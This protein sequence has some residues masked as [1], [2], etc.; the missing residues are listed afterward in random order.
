MKKAKR[1]Q[2]IRNLPQVTQSGREGIQTGVAP[3]HG[4]GSPPP[5]PAE[6]HLQN[7]SPPRAPG[8]PCQSRVTVARM[9][10]DTEPARP[11]NTNREGPS[12]QEAQIQPRTTTGP[13]ETCFFISGL[14]LLKAGLQVHRQSNINGA[15][16]HPLGHLANLSSSSNFSSKPASSKKATRTRPI[17]WLQWAR[18]VPLLQAL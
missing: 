8:R 3:E 6:P 2:I 11:Q 12:Q 7:P 16:P 15:C 9:S 14:G 13:P 1:R 17:S 4:Y 18:S 5:R 10:H